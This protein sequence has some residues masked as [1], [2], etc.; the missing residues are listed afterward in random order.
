MSTTI[1]RQ[2]GPYEILEHIGHGGIATVF[3]ARDTRSAGQHVALKVVPDGPDASSREIAEAEERGAELQRAFLHGS[4]HVPEVFEVGKAGGYLYIA[5]EYLNGEDLSA[6]IRRGPLDARRSAA[7]G[8]QLCKFLEEVDRLQTSAESPSPVTLLHNDLKPSNVRLVSGD[9]IKVLDFG[10]AKTLSMSRRWTKND[11]Y[12]TPY[13]SPECLDSG[14]RDRQTDAWALGVMLYEMVAGAPPF[15]ADDTRRLEDRIRSR[16]PPD[17]LDDCPQSLQAVVAKL[18]APFPENR[19]RDAEAIRQDLER[20]LAGTAT[21]AES[22]GW[23]NRATDEPPTRRTRVEREDE[24]PTR[25]VA[26]VGL[27]EGSNGVP[28]PPQGVIPSTPQPAATSRLGRFSGIRRRLRLAAVVALLGI[29]AHEGCLAAHASRVA[30]TVPMQE[31]GGLTEAWTEYESLSARSWVGGWSARTLGQTL[32]RQ[33]LVLADRVA[34]NYR[35]P[36]PTVREAQWAA[37]ANSLERAL[38]VTPNDATIRGTLRYCQGQLHRINGDARKARRQAAQAQRE[39]TDAVTAFREAAALRQNWP[40]PF[41]GLARTFIYGLEDIDRG[42]DAMKEA[43]RLGYP[44]GSRETAQLADGYRTRGD[45]LERAAADLRGITQERE[46]LIRSRDAYREALNLYA[47][48][49]GYAD[50][51]ANI[52]QTQHRLDEVERKLS[53]FGTGVDDFFRGA[54]RWD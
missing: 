50:V 39:F 20:F 33:A 12:S 10:A 51:P 49:A 7:I 52:K 6:V 41:L 43:Q 8:I 38:T 23:P 32:S 5:M 4:P 48:I 26:A 13:L 34:E 9:R 16:R 36:A 54:I 31:L 45:T 27:P 37:A 44:I 17:A 22:E 30:A 21:L 29:V 53:P 35:T 25:R 40:D 42:A 14:E 47:R 11:F 19:Y 28:L 15:H 2:I 1:F 3:L 18:L 24:P 46:F